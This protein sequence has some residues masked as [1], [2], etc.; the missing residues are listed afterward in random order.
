MHFQKFYD[1]NAG[2]MYTSVQKNNDNIRLVDAERQRFVSHP[3]IHFFELT[4][5]QE[6]EVT[7]NIVSPIAKYL[8]QF[9]ELKVKT[10][11]FFM[12]QKSHVYQMH[13]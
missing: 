4:N 3:G 7:N 12:I 5:H 10:H 13:L 2:P 9:K 11:T 6:E 8:G 1:M